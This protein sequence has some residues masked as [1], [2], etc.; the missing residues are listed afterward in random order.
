MQICPKRV[1][2]LSRGSVAIWLTAF[3]FAGASAQ[4]GAFTT[5]SQPGDSVFCGVYDTC[6]S[7]MPITG[8][9]GSTFT[10]VTDGTVTATSDDTLTAATVPGGGWNNWNSPPAVES[11]TPTV[12]F[13]D[14]DT[15]DTITLSQAVQVFGFE[16]EGDNFG[17]FSITV[18]WLGADSALLGTET[19]SV[20]TPGGALLFAADA[21]A[22]SIES[23]T[24][25]VSGDGTGFALA[26]I[27]DASSSDVVPEPGSFMLLGTGL[28]SSELLA[29]RRLAK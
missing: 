1:V 15:T 29:R 17:T 10:S 26:N 27:R 12:G 6:A 11:S 3:T 20:T 7:L 16:I 5:I 25:S 21:G 13:D 28:L 22:N 19:L 4:A 8:S 14:S 23:A 24:I 18:D 9:D 2:G